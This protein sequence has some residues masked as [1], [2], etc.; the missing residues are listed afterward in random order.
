MATYPNEAYPADATVLSLDGQDDAATGLAY[1]A[2]GVNANSS[3][4]YEVQYNR[5]LQRQNLIL[6]ALRQGMVV[7]EGSLEIGV[8][9]I[10]YTLGGSR[11]TYNGATG[12]LVPD[13]TTSVVYL[14]SS[15]TLQVTTSFPGSISTYLPL[16]TVVAAGGVLTITDE[17]VLA[18]FTV[19]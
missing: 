10:R 16:A 2:R 7:D 18:L 17:R 5:R 12:I 15:N 9:P 6:A 11:K 19:G 3:P 4:S 1:V 8:Y 14:S 13:D